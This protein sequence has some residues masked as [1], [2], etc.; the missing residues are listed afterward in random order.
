LRLQEIWTD[1]RTEGQ[2]N[3]VN[4]ENALF[5]GDIIKIGVVALP[6]GHS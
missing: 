4:D 3:I 5:A 1:R 6:S 2:G